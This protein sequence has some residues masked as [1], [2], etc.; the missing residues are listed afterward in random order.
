MKT[1]ILLYLSLVLILNSC[2]QQKMERQITFGKLSSERWGKQ[3]IYRITDNYILIDTTESYWESRFTKKG[4]QFTESIKIP[5]EDKSIL[6]IFEKIPKNFF[7]EHLQ[8]IDKTGNKTEYL[9]YIDLQ[10]NGNHLC[11][12]IDEYDLPN[13]N[14]LNETT[15]EFKNELHELNSKLYNLTNNYR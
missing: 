5:L 12:I 3:P 13:Y 9:T 2:T 15:I 10:L 8:K 1:R 14:K 7:S 4:Y 11:G 6:T